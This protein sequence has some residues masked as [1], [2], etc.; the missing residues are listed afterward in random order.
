[1]NAASRCAH[2]H[3]GL[4]IDVTL[5]Q[6]EEEAPTIAVPG[7]D[8][9]KRMKVA[10]QVMNR[11]QL[12]FFCASPAVYTAQT[13]DVADD[14]KIQVPTNGFVTTLDFCRC[15]PWHEVGKKE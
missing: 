13:K 2:L 12:A 4:K 8:G 14:V 7:Q 6:I 9:K 15:C 10:R 11:P 1:V 3:P 5:V